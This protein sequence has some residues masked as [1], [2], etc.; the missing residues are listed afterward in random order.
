MEP[1]TVNHVHFV[2]AV[3]ASRKSLEQTEEPDAQ[4]MSEPPGKVHR[5]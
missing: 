1:V 2:D 3:V 4:A 5:R